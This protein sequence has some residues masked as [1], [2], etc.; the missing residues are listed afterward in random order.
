MRK[1]EAKEMVLD[2]MARDLALSG[3]PVVIDPES[4]DPRDPEKF[5]LGGR[6]ACP[7]HHFSGW[8][9]KIDLGWFDGG[10]EE[11][12]VHGHPFYW[13]VFAIPARYGR[14]R[15]HYLV[16]DYLQMR[17][18]VLDFTAPLG[19]DHRDHADWR[20]D[21]HVYS[22]EREGYFRWGDEPVGQRKDPDRVFALDNV[23]TVHDL[24]LI[25]ERVGTFGLGG[26]SA[27][28]RR[29]KLYVAA[30]PTEFGLSAQASPHVEYRFQTGDRVDVLFE[31]H[32]PDRTV[33]E[34]EVAGEQNI[35]VGIHQAIK[36]RSL[37]EADAGYRL[38]DNHVRSLVV[39]YD[40]HYQRAEDLA[41]RYDV[42]LQSVEREKVLSLAS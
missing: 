32:L 9:V 33:V 24:Q 8:H 37:A 40:T 1:R 11:P 5:V 18:W 15:D 16:C 42:A 34:V 29:L 36:Y 39:A 21:V 23:A 30:H 26:E 25:K 17:T 41:D 3:A 31:N 19:R 35:C 14:G 20:A 7:I 6:I 2:L 28:H 27:A 13:Y 10:Y 4:P 22:D 38:M 12:Q